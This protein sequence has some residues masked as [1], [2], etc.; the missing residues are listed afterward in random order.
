MSGY[1]EIDAIALI[2]SEED[3]RCVKP[4]GT[5]LTMFDYGFLSAWKSLPAGLCIRLFYRN[6][7]VFKM[8][9]FRWFAD[10]QRPLDAGSFKSSP[11]LWLFNLNA[12]CS[13]SNPVCWQNQTHIVV[14]TPRA[15]LDSANSA[16]TTSIIAHA[17]DQMFGGF[18]LYQYAIGVQSSSY[19]PQTLMKICPQSNYFYFYFIVF[20]PYW[21]FF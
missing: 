5:N 10:A 15:M 9:N 6:T 20:L 11:K 13:A 12:S 7:I 1:N 2:G 4:A 19:I 17:C 8:I 3:L 16:S 21:F 14:V 18:L